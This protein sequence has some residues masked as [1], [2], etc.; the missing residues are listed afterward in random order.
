MRGGAVSRVLGVMVSRAAGLRRREGRGPAVDKTAPLP[1]PAATTANCGGGDKPEA[2]ASGTTGVADDK[3]AR[4]G[5]GANGGG[6]ANKAESHKAEG[7]KEEEGKRMEDADKEDEDEP[8]VS[9]LGALRAAL[10]WALPRTH[11]LRALCVV[12]IL[13]EVAYNACS[14]AS[15]LL[16]RYAMNELTLSVTGAAADA[17]DTATAAS[18]STAKAAASG[19]VASLVPVAGAKQLLRF[20]PHD[21]APYQRPLVAVV[22]YICTDYASGVLGY[23]RRL[24]WDAVK[25]VLVRDVQI[26]TF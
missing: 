16:L 20:F 8:K 22:A 9:A 21:L 15:P 7:D 2:E 10:P 24:S 3:G 26:S 23:V 4:D 17:A 14:V 11:K 19:V 13:A 6:N 1:P 5:D 25:K 12:S 18:N